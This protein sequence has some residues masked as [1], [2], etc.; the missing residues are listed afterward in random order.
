MVQ[1]DSLSE[2]SEKNDKK[3]PHRSKSETIKTKSSIDHASE[4][5]MKRRREIR[6]MSRLAF[7]DWCE[8]H[9]RNI[10]LQKVME[11][12]SEHDSWEYFSQRG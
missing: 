6:E 7:K 2:Q 11:E 1:K 5:K 3:K 4:V 12:Q 8:K 10:R 9:L